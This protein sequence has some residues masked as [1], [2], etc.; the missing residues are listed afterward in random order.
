MKKP[1]T[2]SHSTYAN[3]FLSHIFRHLTS[4]LWFALT[5]LKVGTPTKKIAVEHHYPQS[6]I[7]NEAPMCPLEAVLTHVK[8]SSANQAKCPRAKQ[9]SKCLVQNY[10][11]T[12]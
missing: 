7:P 4:P 10:R 12:V 9:E 3:I 1:L 11:A 5:F 8:R 2:L 6:I